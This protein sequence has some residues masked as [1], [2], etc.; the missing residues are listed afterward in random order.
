MFSVEGHNI[1]FPCLLSLETM[2]FLMVSAAEGWDNPS[3]SRGH[4][5]ET[6]LWDAV[7]S[8]GPEWYGTE[9]IGVGH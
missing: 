5:K 6:V 7:V 9:S 1:G 2:P 3:V 8:V 4:V